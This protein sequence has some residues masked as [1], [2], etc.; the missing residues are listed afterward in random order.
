M[1]IKQGSISQ[2]GFLE[3]VGFDKVALIMSIVAL[4]CISFPSSVMIGYGGANFAPDFLIP[5]IGVCFLIFYIFVPI[6]TILGLLNLLQGGVKHRIAMAALALN[7]T[8][9]VIVY[10]LYRLYD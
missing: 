2:N 6:G 8:S 5:I 3:R 9:I 10:A 1:T 4:L 7:G